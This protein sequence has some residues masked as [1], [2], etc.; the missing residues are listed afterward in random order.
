MD[1]L[2]YIDLYTLQKILKAGIEASFPVPV[3]VKAEISSLNVKQNGHCYLELSQND[4]SE[5]M[6]KSKAVIWRTRYPMISQY[7]LSAT[8][9]P[10][11]PGMEVLV[12]VRLSYHEVWGI[13]LT[14]DD[15]NPEFT[16][17]EKEMQKKKTLERL[18]REGLMNL[19]KQLRMTPLP[20][21]FAVVSA[22]DAAGYGDFCRHLLHNE[23][24]FAYRV[25]LFEA[26]MQGQTAPASICGALGRVRDAGIRYDAVLVLR[27][28]GSE[29]DLACFDDYE[30]A[31]A[32][33]RFPV[34]VFTA[35]GHDRDHHVAD[36][37]A[38]TSV[39]T[40]TALADFFISCTADEDSRITACE[41]R[42]RLAF[43]NRIAALESASEMLG[44]RILTRVGMRLELEDA[45][46]KF[47]EMKIAAM[48]PRRVL[49]QGVP[50]LLDEDGVKFTSVAG[51]KTGDHISV[52]L[53]DGRIE[54]A[55]TGVIENTKT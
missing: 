16:V 52:M 25:D 54:A 37:V 14:I 49:E 29:L 2:N 13:T 3:W 42:L 22:A 28:G 44:A 19:Q 48:D 8:G 35:I 23:Y 5:V 20:Y 17:G 43:Q 9:T 32:I 30:L 51:R 36:M 6:A 33:A 1:E 34:P 45:K 39:K 41:T 21:R 24:G 11:E 10:L 7:F 46:L 38:H 40:P 47:L 31:A 18:E 55:V 4:G 26:T 12:R 53:P 15:I 27:G 50:L